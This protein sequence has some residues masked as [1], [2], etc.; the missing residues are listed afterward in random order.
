[1]A[2]SSGTQNAG[3]RRYP[4]GL[5]GFDNAPARCAKP[6]SGVEA[7][8][9]AVGGRTEGRRTRGRY[10]GGPPGRRRPIRCRMRRRGS[11]D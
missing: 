10:R 4:T 2:A 9:E 5:L 8:G 3:R 11:A 7:A 6:R 1:M